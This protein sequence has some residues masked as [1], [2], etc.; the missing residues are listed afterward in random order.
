MAEFPLALKASASAFCSSVSM[1][2]ALGCP[3]PV[4]LSPA[5]DAADLLLA[6]SKAP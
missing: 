3:P 6:L 1:L 4:L 5:A 2:G